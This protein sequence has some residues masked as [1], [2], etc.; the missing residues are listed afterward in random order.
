MTRRPPRRRSSGSFIFSHVSGYSWIKRHD[1]SPPMEWAT[2]CTGSLPAQSRIARS[3][4]AALLS[5]SSRQSKA[6]GR[7]CQRLP[8][9]R[10]RGMYSSSRPHVF[11]CI[12]GSARR[13]LGIEGE[14][15]QA[16]IG[17]SQEVDPDEIL[18]ALGIDRRKFAAHDAVDDD[19]TSNDPA[20]PGACRLHHPCDSRRAEARFEFVLASSVRFNDALRAPSTSPSA[21]SFRNRPAK[22]GAHRFNHQHLQVSRPLACGCRQRCPY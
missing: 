2:I 22:G 10:T 14:P 11:I 18:V 4:A 6:N 3:S 19:D 5:M 1:T 12:A 17:Q 8:S 13:S 15:P 20:A 16:S 9:S 7:T 21:N